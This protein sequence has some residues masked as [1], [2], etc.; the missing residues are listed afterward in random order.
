M[1]RAGYISLK[2]YHVLDWLNPFQTRGYFNENC[3][4]TPEL[5][6]LQRSNPPR[7]QLQAGKLKVIVLSVK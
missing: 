2:M 4:G 7:A 1:R 5:K 3:V 6:D